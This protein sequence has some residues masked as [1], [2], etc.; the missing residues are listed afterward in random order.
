M[1]AETEMGCGGGRGG[2]VS[3]SIDMTVLIFKMLLSHGCFDGVAFWRN[4]SNRLR[5]VFSWIF[6]VI[7]VLCD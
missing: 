5:T 3:C 7:L 6:V 4:M 1:S 2:E